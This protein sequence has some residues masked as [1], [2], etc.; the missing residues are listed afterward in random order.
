MHDK[1]DNTSYQERYCNI[2]LTSTPGATSTLGTKIGLPADQNSIQPTT[3]ILFDTGANGLNVANEA[4]LASITRCE[5]TEYN[6][7][8]GSLL[9][10]R[11]GQLRDIGIVHF[12]RRAKLSI[13]SASD[14][15]R[16]GHQ[17]EFRAGDHIDDDAFLL[18]TKNSTYSFK[19]RDGLY[20]AD[21]AISPEPRYLDAPRGRNSNSNVAIV[22]K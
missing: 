10:T 22:C 8:S 12:D 17:F 6:G 4:I 18:H 21:M 14:C 16:Q 1:E 7:L 2:T 19:H 15:L 20:I 3:E 11:T 13:L 5:P 9:V